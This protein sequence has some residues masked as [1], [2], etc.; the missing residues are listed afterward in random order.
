MICPLSWVFL[1][2]LYKS[3][4]WIS[5]VHSSN[6]AL[7]Y[8]DLLQGSYCVPA[9]CSL[10]CEELRALT[11]ITTKT[12]LREADS[13]QVTEPNS[14]SDFCLHILFWIASELISLREFIAAVKRCLSIYQNYCFFRFFLLRSF[15]LKYTCSWIL[16]ILTSIFLNN[17]LW[18][19][20]IPYLT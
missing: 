19:W 17:E 4:S 10:C 1:T 5:F 20:I 9:Y 6:W 13:S 14:G 3:S 8:F 7:H 11:S 12:Y 16:V 15:S 2:Q 18:F